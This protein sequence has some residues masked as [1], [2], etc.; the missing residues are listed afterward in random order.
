M[1]KLNLHPIINHINLPTVIKTA[2]FPGDWQESIFIAT[3]PGE[4]IYI[5]GGQSGLFLDIKQNVL[6]LGGPRGGYDERGLLGLAFHP[7]FYYNGLFYLHY[8][9]SD[10]QGMGALSAPFRPNPP[11]GQTVSLMRRAL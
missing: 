3:Q 8:S 7:M 10:S 1:L 9:L 6:R 11:I 4:I 2:A 5:R